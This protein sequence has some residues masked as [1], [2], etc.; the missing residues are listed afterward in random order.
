M[1]E[2]TVSGLSAIDPSVMDA[3][4]KSNQ[5]AMKSFERLSQYFFDSMR[6]NF[7]TA[8]EMNKRLS[9]V[10]SLPELAA[11]QTKLTQEFFDHVTESNKTVTELSTNMVH[12]VATRSHK[13]GGARAA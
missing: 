4:V 3:F 8:I 7:E 5:V 6:R 11:L 10:K 1:T 2:K 9:A 12:D 13:N